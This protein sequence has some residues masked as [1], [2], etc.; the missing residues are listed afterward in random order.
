MHD[1]ILEIPVTIEEV[2]RKL[3]TSGKGMVFLTLESK[4]VASI[5]DGDVRRALLSG[6]KL[7]AS[8][9]EIAN[10]NVRFLTE[11]SLPVEYQ[12]IFGSGIVYVPIL[13]SSRKILKIVKQDDTFFIPL[14][15]PNLGIL[16]SKLVNETIDKNWISSSGVFVSQFESLFSEYVE[17][18]HAV[19]V[20][21]G[22]L[23]LV[24]ALKLLNIG[25]G[26]EVIIPNLTFGA[27]ANSVIQVGATPVFVDVLSD[28]FS[29][30]PLLLNKKISKRT[31]AIIVVH[32]Y[33]NCGPLDEIIV[34]A[35][36][37]GIYL[38]EDAA[39]A[40]GT[41]YKEKHVGTFGDVGVFS[42]FANKTITTGE[43]GMLVFDDTSILRNARMMRSHGFAPENRY[44]HEIWGSNFRLTN[45]QAAL[46]VAQ[47][48][49][50]DELVKA[51][52]ENANFYMKLLAPLE[53]KH[54][55]FPKIQKDV[56]NSYWLFTVNLIDPSLIE[57]LAEFLL[58]NHVETRRFFHPLNSQPAFVLYQ[59]EEDFPISNKLYESGLC[60]PSST[61]LNYED[62][63]FVT[64]KIIEFFT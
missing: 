20:S 64:R 43:G 16:E 47:M 55:R 28:S 29:I 52:I 62:I 36:Q 59:N 27:T 22:T 63:S 3:T 46:G 61:K 11:Y 4:L 48:E 33:G 54:L 35:K 50:V 18:R 37:N 12:Q 40:I 13:D 5:S 57:S 49:R 23:G 24:L 21:N 15:E 53:G 10:E 19:S 45:I 25:P 31:K 41:R 8:A 1:F 2:M 32:L 9:T 60:L 6:K 26:D 38:I 44:W 34:F 51:K 58:L 14:S 39:E 17:S 30:D 56:Q 7:E 42:F